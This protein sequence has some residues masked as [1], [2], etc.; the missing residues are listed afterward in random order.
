MTQRELFPGGVGLFC[1][2]LFFVGPPLLGGW[3][4]VGFWE[5][6]PRGVPLFWGE[7]VGGA[8]HSFGKIGAYGR[9]FVIGRG[10][11]SKVH[12]AVGERGGL[13]VG[14]DGKTRFGREDV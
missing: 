2:F 3:V 4:C 8:S 13:G 7:S 14:G 6:V 5:L 10:F 1:P 12:G 11:W 9:V